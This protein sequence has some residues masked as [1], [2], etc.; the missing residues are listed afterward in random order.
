M[1]SDL[2]GR[3]MCIQDAG[4]PT[5]AEMLLQM[6]ANAS[7]FLGVVRYSSEGRK[8]TEV[9]RCDHACPASCA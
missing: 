5:M 2:T 9:L 1:A 7:G 6:M 4:C 3:D 8:Y